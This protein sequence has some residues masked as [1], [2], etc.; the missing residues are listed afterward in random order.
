QHML[1]HRPSMVGV[2]G[3]YMIDD[4]N[5]LATKSEAARGKF[6]AIRDEVG[7]RLEAEKV[8]PADVA[9]WIDLNRA[10]SDNQLTLGW[11]DRVKDERRKKSLIGISH[12]LDALLIAEG[13]WTDLALTRSDPMFSLENL[14]AARAGL[15]KPFKSEAA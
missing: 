5:R 15:T 14:R 12:Q 13:R 9:D 8:A 7:K 10:L 6:A 11:F 3:S 4:M 1:D 2:R